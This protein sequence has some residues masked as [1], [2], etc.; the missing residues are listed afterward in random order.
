MINRLV[1]YFLE[2]RLV[3][4]IFLVAFVVLGVAY[5][6]FSWKTGALPRDPIPVDAIPD[7][8]DNQQIVA[9]E[10]MG[11]SPKD[12][13]DQVTYPLTTALLGIPGVQTVRSTSMFGMSFIYIIFKDKVEFYW[14]RSR[15]LEKL[16]SLPAGTL[17]AGVTPTLGPDATALGQIFWYTLEGR[18]PKTGKPNGGWSPQELRTIQDFYVKYG[19]STAE[20]VS[21]VASVGGFVKE[22][23]VDVNPEALKAYNVSVM[24]VMNAVRKSNLDIGA[25][26]V[27]LNSVEYIIR[28]LG[29]V[30]SLDD[31][32]N[33]VVAVRSNVPVRIRDVAHTTFGPATRRGGLDKA[34]SEVVGAVVVARYGSNPMEVI[35]NVKDKVKEIDAG[36]PQKKLPD[37]TISKVT[38]VPFYDRTGLIKETIGTLESALSHEI[39]I[40]IIVIIVLVINLRA[41][42]II[43]GLLPIAVLMTFIVMRF[44]GVDANIVA[45]SGI[46]I[47]IGVMVDIGIIY[48]ENIVRHLEMPENRNLQGKPLHQLILKATSEVSP[49]VTT[50]LA[51]TV[52]S[53]LPVFAMEAAEGKL[54]RPLAFTKTFA[55]L[56]SF[57]LGIIVLPTLAH[58]IFSIRFDTKKIRK[59]WNGSLIAAGLLFVV[60]WETWPALALT[61]IGINNFLDYRWPEGRKEYPNYINIGITL[62]VAVYYLSIEWLP[63]GAHNS[64]LVNFLFV[65]GIVAVILTALMLMVHYYERIIRWCLVNKAKFLLIPAFTLLFGI[66]AWQGFDRG[67][68]FVATG[69]EKMGWHSFRQT[70]LWQ[71]PSKA[72][73]GTGK[74]FMPSLNEGSF[75]LMPTSMPHTSIEK[76]LDYVETLDKRLSTIPEVEV[77]VGKWGRVNSALDPAP[78]QMFENTINY[79]SEYIL[80]ENGHRMRFKVD[81][82]GRYIL[83]NGSKYNPKEE[84][85][86]IIPSD[87]L[88]TDSQGEYFRQWRSEIK[89]PLD[90]WNEIVK[91]TNIPGL[92]SA[93]KLQPIE[94]RLVML[95]TGMRAPM[96][97]K[98]YGPDLESIE[99]GGMVLEQ[100]LK[101][102]PSIKSSS[103]FYDRTVGAP[104][105]EIK[106]NREAMARYG[107]SISDVQEILQ[108]AIGGMTLNTSVEGRERF[109]MRVRYARELRDNPDDIKR[110]LIP[111]L[112]GAQ[113]PLGEIADVGYTKGAQMIRSEN[114]FLVGYVIFDKVEGKAEVDVVEDAAKIIKQKV[115]SGTIKLPA[116]VSYKFAGNYEQQIRATKRLA[117][118]IPVSLIIIFLLLYFQFRTITASFI[119]FSGV[120]V[121]FAGGFIMLW[122]YGQDWFMNFSIAGVNLRDMF[123]MHHINLSVAVWVGFIALF[124]IATNDGVIMGTYIH[125]VFEQ[126]HPSTVHEV[127]E[128]VVAAGLKRVR[129]AMMTTAVAIIALLPVLTSTGKGADIMVPM[130]IP[131]FGGM[132]IQMMTIFVVPI[133]QSM[134]RE[135]AIGRISNDVQTSNE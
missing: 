47:A 28:G 36:L 108:V 127:R 129:P 52:V 25:E 81:K 7:I 53:F 94:T 38:V 122:L 95:S 64:T 66:L 10:W 31:L 8:G 71:G 74:E 9:T 128:A 57:V 104:Y 78:V 84:G 65:T 29:Y 42:I 90:I 85:F 6:P 40:S 50:A 121:A 105:I 92:T 39:L 4:F 124:G 34:G 35:N 125:Q 43:S 21:E 59:I 72:F 67:L 51:T 13:Q 87:S 20:G 15:I 45:L 82:D 75:L 80:D 19:L 102:I 114:T 83:R 68:G 61:A 14:S 106:L 77:A 111:A 110:I 101:E 100:A 107:M 103:V 131:T 134:W 97:L 22:Y 3:T 46:A 33:S 56:S 99:K 1:K 63:L 62:L 115:D 2:N 113:I 30:K 32:D 112:N 69:L 37:G 44:F 73:P 16:N 49:A 132:I 60:F 86:R 18:T 5:A 96:G 24:D 135:R 91:V 89:K 98:V 88:I 120:F 126:R 27:E 119:H 117:I 11:R 70:A 133:F 48:V 55:L 118:L 54:F 93:P 109:P 17:P 41:S 12:I 26:T 123:Q 58:I 116:G 23:Q 76:N 79:R 130:A